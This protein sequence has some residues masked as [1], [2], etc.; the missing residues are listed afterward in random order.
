[1]EMSGIIFYNS[2]IKTNN[3]NLKSKL[4]IAYGATNN[5]FRQIF[6]CLFAQ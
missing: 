3:K 2:N 5:I 4:L 1:M 6:H